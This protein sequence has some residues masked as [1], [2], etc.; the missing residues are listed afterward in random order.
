MIAGACCACIVFVVLMVFSIYSAMNARG[1]EYHDRHHAHYQN[2]INKA[3]E[4]CCNDQDCGQLRDSDERTSNGYLEV[5]VEGQWCPV[6]SRHYLRS[7]NVPDAS[8]AHVCAWRSHQK[9]HLGPC[10]RLL[11]YQ[12]KPGS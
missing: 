6:L 3:G 11:C 10:E 1:Q 7:G 12:P 9:P 5:R 8:T 2:W 4:G